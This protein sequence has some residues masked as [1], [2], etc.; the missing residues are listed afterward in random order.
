MRLLT[1]AL[2]GVLLTTACA[3]DAGDATDDL[4][5]EEGETWVLVDGEVDGAPIVV[6]DGAR[7][8]LTFRADQDGQ[9]GAG[10]TA[11][12]NSW[13]GRVVLGGGDAIGFGEIGQTEMACEEPAMTAESMFLSG[14][15]RVDRGERTSDTLHLTGDTVDYRFELAPKLP[16]EALVGTTWHLDTIIDG[17]AASNTMGEPATLLLTADGQVEGSTGCRELTGTYVVV[18][19]E[20]Q[21]TNLRADGECPADLADQ[22]AHVIEVIA[23]GFT[24]TVDGQRLTLSSRGN[25]GLSYTSA[26]P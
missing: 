13:F 6:P 11:A 2:V 1:C 16:T 7:V 5:F 26:Q 24:A 22:D 20:V 8:D 17:D 12:C 4:A 25:M 21:M 10:G 9:L 3:S 15:M 18:G 19:D 23:D 14:L